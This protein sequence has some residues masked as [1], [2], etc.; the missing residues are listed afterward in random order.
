MVTVELSGDVDI[1]VKEDLR[2]RLDAAAEQ[3]N[4][5][6]IDLS[7]VQYADSTAL[8]LIIALRNR[9][10]ERG[11]TVRLVAPSDRVRKLLNYAGLDNAFEIIER[12]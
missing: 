3:S 6:D 4:T 10:R 2:A 12:S 9:L 11:G 8:G 1:A 5:V 7:K